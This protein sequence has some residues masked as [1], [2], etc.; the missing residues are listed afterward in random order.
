MDANF[1][2]N[3]MAMD[4]FAVLA[5]VNGTGVPL[6]YCFTQLFK[7]NDR[8]VRRTEP[9]ALTAILEQFLRPLQASGFNPTFFGT[10]KDSS[11]ISAIRPVWPGT[12]IQLCYW[13]A[14]RAIR[15]KLT[16]SRQPNFQGYYNPLEAQ[17]RIPDLEICLAS[18]PIR[19]P[20]GDHRYGRVLA[21]RGQRILFPMVRW[22]RQP[23]M[24]R[25][26]SLRSFL[27]TTMPTH[28][29][30]IR[31][32]FSDLQRIFIIS[33]LQKCITGAESGITFDNGPIFGSTGTTQTSGNCGRDQLMKRKFRS[34]RQQ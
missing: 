27:D 17:A 13:H 24:N 8:G 26:P 5:E 28:L 6:A 3:N 31:M 18:R 12:T 1:G 29:S 16:S 20:N 30:P 4:L 7:D 9:G 11:E 23:R 21:P 25:I 14:W 33:V 34:S 15:T 22:K 10:D 2:T 32:I 19:R